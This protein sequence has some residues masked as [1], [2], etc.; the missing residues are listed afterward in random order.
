MDMCWHRW[1]V[2]E[3]EILPSLL[4]QIG[5]GAMKSI[6]GRGGIEALHRKSVIV[7][8]GCIKCGAGK[9]VRL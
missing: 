8:Y 3:K 9:V 4:E 2:K 7:T 1:V 6:K 5:D